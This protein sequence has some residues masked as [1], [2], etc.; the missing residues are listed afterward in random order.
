MSGPSVRAAAVAHG[1]P[2]T[3]TPAARSASVVPYEPRLF[4]RDLDQRRVDLS[5][6]LARHLTGGGCYLGEEI[7]E[8]AAHQDML[9]QRHRPSFRD[10]DRHLA[11]HL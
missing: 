8:R 11:T 9:E 6:A 7:V 1:A 3:P 10:D 2:A 5:L 4:P